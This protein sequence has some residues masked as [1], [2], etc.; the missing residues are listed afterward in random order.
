MQNVQQ[1]ESLLEIL[2]DCKIILHNIP[3]FHRVPSNSKH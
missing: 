2:E 3:D 1:D